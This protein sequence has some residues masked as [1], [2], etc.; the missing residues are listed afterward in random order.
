MMILLKLWVISVLAGIS[1]CNENVKYAEQTG[2]SQSSHD[3]YHD[4]KELQEQVRKLE[5]IMETVL[6]SSNLDEQQK[7]EM[8]LNLQKR[9]IEDDVQ[10]NKEDIIDLRINDGRHDMLISQGML[11]TNYIN[12]TIIPDM[13]QRFDAKV[14]ELE[15]YDSYID[16]TRPPIGSIIA[17]LPSYSAKAE[18][19]T[20][21]QRC[22]GSDITKGP[23]AGRKTPDLNNVKRFLRGSSDADSGTFEEDSVQDHLHADPGHR[24]TVS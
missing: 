15:E 21:W 6:L 10:Q 3:C 11:M 1:L 9:A 22:D 20:G 12:N 17:W 4:I 24:H 23:L 8:V 13:K 5:G 16:S 14:D 19:P 18:I 2:G 7:Q